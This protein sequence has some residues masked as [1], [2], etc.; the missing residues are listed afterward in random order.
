MSFPTLFR[1]IFKIFSPP[2]RLK[3]Y[4]MQLLILMSAV[5]EITGVASVM[6]FMQAVGNPGALRE[7]VSTIGYLDF[8]T[9]Y[10]TKELIIF[11]GLTS[12]FIMS[13]SAI[14]SI[15]LT[16]RLA[17]FS[18]SIGVNF[19]DRLFENY[20]GSSWTF[21]AN[22]NSAD[23][24]KQIAV[25]SQRFA[26]LVMLPIMMMNSKIVLVLIFLVAFVI[27]DPHVAIVAGLVFLFVY[28]I[29]YKVVKKRL[30]WNGQI[31]SDTYSKRFRILSEGLMGIRDLIILRRL[32]GY[33][34]AFNKH[35]IM[36]S[37]AKGLN[38]AL[39][40]GPRYLIELLAFGSMTGIVLYLYIENDRN[41]GGLLAIMTAYALAGLKV[42]PSVQQIYV[43]LAHVR[44]NSESF[45]II[46]DDLM[47]DNEDRADIR[48][49]NVKKSHPL[50]DSKVAIDV[51]NLTFSY[52][53]DNIAIKDMSFVVNTGE[54]VG[55]IGSSGS[56]KSTLMDLVCGL[57]EATSGTIGFGKKSNGSD[58][59]MAV[60][61]QDI[62]LTDGTIR[63]NVA[64]GVGIEN[65]CDDKVLKALE[66]SHLADVVNLMDY[67]LDTELGE[68]GVK[69]SGGQRQRI[70]IA[71]A[72]YSKPDIIVFDE[73]TSALDGVS[74]RQVMDT[75]NSLA[76]ESTIL[77][78][79]HRLESVKKCD[80]I[81]LLEHGV[82]KDF[83]SFLELQL[84]HPEFFGSTK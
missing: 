48:R 45:Y 22:R 51:R 81:F 9:L 84:R 44:G 79:A 65:I 20:M 72:I 61:H 43:A 16:Y 18:A 8:M 34:R 76:G 60:V 69:L 24:T 74:E 7:T 53:A 1:D 59:N 38:V 73:A 66:S 40:Q 6:P 75:I 50:P 13:A 68:R 5:F 54:M 32:E 49:G 71:R 33:P 78:V 55:F 36:L 21:H 19:A 67:G 30:A 47:L 27:Q 35:G 25:E 37:R 15:Y 64:L 77:I 42:L 17:I 63:D 83:G 56:G 39:A 58:L 29:L 46:R 70:A 26:D 62:F 12:L 52:E 82:I 57:L 3:L 28:M 80:K 41:I 14:C 11:L 10:N 23:M 4:K 2:Q 31:I